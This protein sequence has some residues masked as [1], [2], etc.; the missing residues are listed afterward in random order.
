MFHLPGGW[1]FNSPVQG[2]SHCRENIWVLNGPNPLF[3]AEKLTHWELITYFHNFHNIE[4]NEC[5]DAAVGST[6]YLFVFVS[7]NFVE[8]FGLRYGNSIWNWRQ[9]CC[10]WRPSSS[11]ELLFLNSVTQLSHSMTNSDSTSQQNFRILTTHRRHRPKLLSSTLH[12]HQ[13]IWSTRLFSI[14]WF[15]FGQCLICQVLGEFGPCWFR[16]TIDRDNILGLPVGGLTL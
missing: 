10:S 6:T 7:I 9:L 4:E 1:L 14:D 15:S 12:Y 8:V 13:G 2:Q 3:F 11:R 5:S 16:L